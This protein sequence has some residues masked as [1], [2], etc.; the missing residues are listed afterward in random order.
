MDSFDGESRKTLLSIDLM[1][2][3]IHVNLLMENEKENCLQSDP[4]RHEKGKMRRGSLTCAGLANL[5]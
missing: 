1:L 5:Q 2:A 3:I 4:W